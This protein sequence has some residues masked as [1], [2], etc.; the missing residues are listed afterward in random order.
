MA[1]RDLGHFRGWGGG[2]ELGTN[3]QTQLPSPAQLPG[4]RQTGSGRALERPLGKWKWTCSTER[5]T[6]GDDRAPE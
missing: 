5:Q 6:Q 1:I 3:D 4:H 2:R